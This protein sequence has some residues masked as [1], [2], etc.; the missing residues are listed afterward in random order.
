AAPHVRRFGNDLTIQIKPMEQVPSITPP[1]APSASG[2]RGTDRKATAMCHRR[3]KQANGTG[4]LV[5]GLALSLAG[6]ALAAGQEPDLTP[7]ERQ[8]LEAQAKE[9]YGRLLKFYD[10]AKLTDALKEAQQVLTINRRLYPESKYPDGHRDLATSLN[11][12]GFVLQAM[13]RPD[14]ALGY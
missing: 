7:Q 11:N 13:E 1:P 2:T 6:L 8:K 9:C 4:L 12:L 14:A 5:L 3:G 10:E